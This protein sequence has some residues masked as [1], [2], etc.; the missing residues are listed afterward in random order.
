MVDCLSLRT[1]KA[2]VDPVQTL[3]AQAAISLLAT[4]L[5]LQRHAF[6]FAGT[7]DKRA[8][9]VQGVTLEKVRHSTI[10]GPFHI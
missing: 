3:L 1:R 7:K 2:I 4:T 10:I 9:T 6:G 8:C 5:R